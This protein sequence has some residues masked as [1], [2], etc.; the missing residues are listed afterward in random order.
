LNLYDHFDRSPRLKRN[1]VGFLV[2]ARSLQIGFSRP[3]G[4]HISWFL[5]DYRPPDVPGVLPLHVSRSS[6]TGGC[7][8]RELSSA[9]FRL[10]GQQQASG[11]PTTA[12][13]TNVAFL[14]TKQQATW[15]YADGTR[16]VNNAVDLRRIE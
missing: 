3:P 12:V 6:P 10:V 15:A 14:L 11:D 13:V 9:Q 4:T 1:L 8:G 2:N 5:L 16:L 7:L